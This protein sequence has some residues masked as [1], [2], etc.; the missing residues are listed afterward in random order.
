MP[1]DAIE[2]GE[3]SERVTG[4]NNGRMTSNGLCASRGTIATADPHIAMHVGEPL[5]IVE[6]F[7]S[8]EPDLTLLLVMQTRLVNVAA[9]VSYH[10]LQASDP[11]GAPW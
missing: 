10:A 1:A 9:R 7:V 8:I 3:T 11:I 2:V 4:T 5:V 6:A